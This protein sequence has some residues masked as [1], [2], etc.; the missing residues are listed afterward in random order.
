[1]RRSTVLLA[2]DYQLVRAGL[3]AL[4]EDEADVELDTPPAKVAS[5]RIPVSCK[6]TEGAPT[7]LTVRGS[8]AGCAEERAPILGYHP[9]TVSKLDSAASLPGVAPARPRCDP[10]VVPMWVD[11][12]GNHT[13]VSPGS[14]RYLTGVSGAIQHV[15]FRLKDFLVWPRKGRSDDSPVGSGADRWLG[16]R[17]EGRP[18]CKK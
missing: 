15:T 1:M 11:P 3:R 5:G 10:G 2:G 18:S 16:R 6:G 4:L 12:H 17:Q 8:T 7:F 14:H 9:P 13:G